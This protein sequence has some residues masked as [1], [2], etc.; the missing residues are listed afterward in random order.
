MKFQSPENRFTWKIQIYCTN[1]YCYNV[2]HSMK[3]SIMNNVT[4][5]PLHIDSFDF[6]AFAASILLLLQ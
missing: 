5:K 1:S 4:S 3:L 2:K 6:D